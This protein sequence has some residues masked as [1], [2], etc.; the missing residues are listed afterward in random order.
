MFEELQKYAYKCKNSNMKEKII[1]LIKIVINLL[2]LSGFSLRW[3]V[4]K[5]LKL[6]Q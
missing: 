3:K 1:K 4:E 5:L 6:Q 2:I